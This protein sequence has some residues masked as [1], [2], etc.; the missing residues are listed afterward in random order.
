MASHDIAETPRRIIS[1]G[2]DELDSRIGGGLPS[3]SVTLIEGGSG[4]GKSVLAEQIVW[5]ALR[6]GLRAAIFTSENTVKSLIRQMQSI[7]LDVLDYLL[8]GRL[9][10]YPMELSRR[11]AAAPSALLAAMRREAD[12]DLLVI[13]SLTAALIHAVDDKGVIAF[14]EGCKRISASGTSILVVLHSDVIEADFISPIRSMCDADLQLRMEQDGQRLVKT[15]Q[16]AKIRG[17]TNITGGIV[18]FE[19]EPGFGLRVIPISKARG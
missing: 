18:G 13:D 7:E 14:F 6:D 11:G 19:V 10:I 3:G 1:S 16:V 5:G 4:S 17:A 2:N 15:L 8:L 9:R 12:R